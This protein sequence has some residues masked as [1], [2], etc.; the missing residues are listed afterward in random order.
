MNVMVDI[1]LDV[2]YERRAK[3]KAY[4]V[5]KYGSEQIEKLGTFTNDPWVISRK[6]GNRVRYQNKNTGAWD[7]AWYALFVKVP[8]GTNILGL[9]VTEFNAVCKITGW[10]P[11]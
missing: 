4:L 1:D 3:I 10:L 9:N 7:P 2:D 6:K 8:A 5:D 11:R